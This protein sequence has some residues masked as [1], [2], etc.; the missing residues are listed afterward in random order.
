MLTSF[1]L[2][3]FS[4]TE[5]HCSKAL[6]GLLHFGFTHTLGLA[7]NRLGPAASLTSKTQGQLSYVLV[8]FSFHLIPT[9]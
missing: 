4:E 6:P 8:F 5:N 1:F 7:G 3:T 2:S 9:Y